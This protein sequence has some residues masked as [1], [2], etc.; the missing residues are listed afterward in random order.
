M[1][2]T[3][4]RT[5]TE[6]LQ[7]RSSKAHNIRFYSGIGI[8]IGIGIN[9]DGLQL[10][11]PNTT[12]PGSELVSKFLSYYSDSEPLPSQELLS[13]AATP[14]SPASASSTASSFSQMH[15]D[16]S[17]ERS[18]STAS[19][20]SERNGNHSSGSASSL[21]DSATA[22]ARV[23][24]AWQDRAGGPGAS[25]AA[26]VAA[27]V[28]AL[29]GSLTAPASDDAV[30]WHGAPQ[31][32]DGR[33]QSSA[34]AMSTP[35][36]GHGDFGAH[37]REGSAPVPGVSTDNQ[38]KR[39][40][41][42]FLALL[43]SAAAYVDKSS[44]AEQFINAQKQQQQ[45][46]Q[47][48]HAQQRDHQHEENSY[49]AT[50]E[51]LSTANLTLSG[52]NGGYGRIEASAGEDQ[53]GFGA[54]HYG[55]PLTDSAYQDIA[56]ALQH[57]AA[58]SVNSDSSALASS[59]AAAGNDLHT[60]MQYSAQNSYTSP[61]NG[62]ID[63]K[64]AASASGPIKLEQIL[65]D[66]QQFVVNSASNGP[67]GSGQQDSDIEMAAGTTA[68]SGAAGAELGASVQLATGSKRKRKSGGSGGG[69]S[70]AATHTP[71][72]R[73]NSQ[74]SDRSIKNTPNP[75]TRRAA[76]KWSEQESESLLQGCA[77]YGVGAWKKI[78]DDPSFT[79]NNR[80]SVDLKDRFRT[81]RAQECAQSP[82]SK[83]AA[84]NAGKV[85]DVVWPLPPNS[86][87]L[88]GLRRV[89]RKP[90]RNYT[91]D[92]DRR[93]LI[94][95]LRHANHW[96][97]IAADP[98]LKLNDRPGQSL[99]DR[100]RNAFPEVF[101]L[102]GYVIPKKE[103]ADRERNPS[104]GPSL[105]YSKAESPPAVTTATTPKRKAPTGSKR[106]EGDVPENIRTKI[107]E[108]LSNM[109]ASLDPHPIPED[110]VDSSYDADA[111]ADADADGDVD[112]DGDGD[113]NG[114]LVPNPRHTANAD[115]SSSAMDVD[116]PHMGA[117]MA[118][119]TSTKAS[120]ARKSKSA[121][122]NS[123]AETSSTG[124]DDDQPLA[125]LDAGATGGA[126]KKTP[127]KRARAKSKTGG[128][129]KDKQGLAP[130]SVS[131][132]EDVAG[133][134]VK[135]E[136][137]DGGIHSAP[138]HMSGAAGCGQLS[139]MSAFGDSIEHRRSGTVS[140][141]GP[142]GQHQH[143]HRNF[144][145]E[146]FAPSMF[147]RPV[148]MMTPTDQLDALA[149]EGRGISG[150]STPNQSA[151]K[152]RHSVQTDFNDVV[153]A[154]ADAAGFDRTNFNSALQ[155][156]NT[157]G[158]AGL[159]HTAATT[160]GVSDA[161]QLSTA[162]TIRRMTIGGPMPMAADAF[163]FP[164]LPD[165]DNTAAAAAAAAAAAVAD[166][167]AQMSSAQSTAATPA[168][169]SGHIVS[170]ISTSSAVSS[171]AA[172]A[173]AAV[174]AVAAGVPGMGMSSAG[175]SGA[176]KVPGAALCGS[177]NGPTLSTSAP[178]SLSG[179]TMDGRDGQQLHTG[180]GHRGQLRSA[181]RLLRA[182]GVADD[183]SIGLSTNPVAGEGRMDFD[184]L[185]Q[186]TQ[187]FPSFGQPGLAWN[188]ADSSGQMG[189]DSIDPNMLDAGL[190]SAA[191]VGATNAGSGSAAAAGGTGSAAAGGAGGAS[192]LS[193]GGGDAT[194]THSRRRSQF[195]WYGLTPSL[196]AHLDAA[197]VSAAAAA[198][199]VAAQAAVTD[200]SAISSLSPFGIAQG[201]VNQT[202]RRPSM[203]VFPTFHYPSGDILGMAAGGPGLQSHHGHQHHSQSL[204]SD[205][206]GHDQ[207]I[208]FGPSNQD[209]ASG[210]LP[211]DMGTG[212]EAMDG[213]SG[214]DS[215]MAGVTGGDVG[216]V[217][218]FVG[219]QQ[220]GAASNTG[221]AG[222]GRSRV[223]G[224]TGTSRRRTMHVPPSLPEDVV[225]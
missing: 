68:A 81:I 30:L 105:A 103:R 70:G 26:A 41:M 147:S 62:F 75:D 116:D 45:H 157:A 216:D 143:Q 101:E 220:F 151:S 78:L 91:N 57:I 181:Q 84:K 7:P 9:V 94:G 127:A 199:A 92:E 54:H 93:L 10:I 184:A 12:T 183:N 154:A 136:A 185:N 114:D 109:N 65:A 145:M 211:M 52:I 19:T 3:L 175:T 129:K 50:S 192:G 135:L 56:Q 141:G 222:G 215:Y 164:R 63:P 182:N 128:G 124:G 29:T 132:N 159:E 193:L 167:S 112:G 224:A 77:K 138:S 83:N 76:R 88:H 42:S 186:L 21:G 40:D 200:N 152:R 139:A 18:S 126:R 106:L 60:Q 169:D 13:A 44:G 110:D 162:D 89:Q 98:V 96:T 99:R 36:Q 156:F 100:L 207:G 217:S 160:G 225:T 34:T 171:S 133:G 43:N 17:K 174:A 58:T 55:Q 79:F 115:N 95:V 16:K 209:A 82:H 148:G 197:N 66:G 134:G 180:G 31:T 195:D 1:Q 59:V 74:A 140:A 104:P 90:T 32:P 158:M 194:M 80:T 113:A 172:A 73:K 218:G 69:A 102:F 97:K 121:A 6:S 189:G 49:L 51:L 150:Y 87:R 190:A 203:P 8:G 223:A 146:S 155:F 179:S 187:W 39:P 86:Q 188:I 28:A 173:A 210:M 25:S 191:M 118:P 213:G 111:D 47:H 72:K 117:M 177:N 33:L 168:S 35:H 206:G 108:V 214:T 131:S 130:L 53:S 85:P 67:N 61:G 196:L 198:A 14:A 20:D 165:D 219:P 137:N 2:D 144:L 201:S 4:L 161:M 24:A 120:T 37:V 163:L 107:L 5:S 64:S 202:Y 178:I 119:V 142:F 38:R 23:L 11:S 122:R 27:T 205:G 15:V 221:S 149:L 176:F 123:V 170:G 204:A 71:S 125:S 46:H 153:A 48:H 166:I 212:G 208:V 22:A